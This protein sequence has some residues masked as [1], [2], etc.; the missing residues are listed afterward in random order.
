M[1]FWKK[2]FRP[3]ENL[4]IGSGGS[5]PQYL[6][7]SPRLMASAVARAYNGGLGQSPQRGP[8]DQGA[9]PPWSWS[10]FGFC[11]FNGIRKFARFSKIL[12]CKIIKN[13]CYLCKKSWVPTKLGGAGAKLGAC[14]PPPS[15]P[16][17]KPPLDM[18]KSR[19]ARFYGPWCMYKVLCL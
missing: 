13:A 3:E 6:G 9:K 16:G 10:T 15:G 8:G 14:A 5:S 1:Y 12:K 7:A 4:P 2:V 17:L 11:T 19:V 18:D